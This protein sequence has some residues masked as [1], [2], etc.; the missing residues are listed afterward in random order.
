MTP[1]TLPM[2]I[3]GWESNILVDVDVMVLLARIPLALAFHKLGH[4]A[5]DH[6][7]MNITANIQLCKGS[8]Y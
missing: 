3:L 1:T 4:N 8:L 7:F 6:T 2:I 5:E